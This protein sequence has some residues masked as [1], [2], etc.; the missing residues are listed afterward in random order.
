MEMLRTAR[1]PMRDRTVA[2]QTVQVTRLEAVKGKFSDGSTKI[3]EVTRSLRPIRMAS[4][5]C[6]SSEVLSWDADLDKALKKAAKK[7]S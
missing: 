7:L 6:P 4:L 3:Y 1:F 2:G 5:V